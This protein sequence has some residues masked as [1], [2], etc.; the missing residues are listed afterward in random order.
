[1]QAKKLRRK[2]I[3]SLYIGR[4]RSYNGSGRAAD[5]LP[6]PR[7]VAE[8][9]P[10]RPHPVAK[11]RLAQRPTSRESRAVRYGRGE[12]HCSR[13]SRLYSAHSDGCNF[14][15]AK[16]NRFRRIFRLYYV[17][18][19]PMV[20]RCNGALKGPSNASRLEIH[21]LAGCCS[22]NL[23]HL[24]RCCYA[25]RVRSVGRCYVRARR[26]SVTWTPNSNSSITCLA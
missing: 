21:R 22:S 10:I 12:K 8:R 24:R 4:N 18:V 25:A 26:G 15:I 19:G 17:Q 20:I 23:P 13:C 9:R 2:R 1:M 11:S 14:C 3:I 6:P 16:L 7:L 5:L